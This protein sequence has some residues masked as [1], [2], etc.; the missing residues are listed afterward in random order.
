MHQKPTIITWPV[1]Y[2]AAWAAPNAQKAAAERAAMRESF[3]D[4]ARVPLRYSRF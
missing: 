1:V 4:L 2:C 3:T